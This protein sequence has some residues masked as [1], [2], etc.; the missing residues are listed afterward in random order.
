MTPSALTLS[1]LLAG[2]ASAL[3]F[4][5]F[6]GGPERGYERDDRRGEHRHERGHQSVQ[7]G[8]RPQWLVDDMD[9]SHLKRRL[10]RCD[11]NKP[12]SSRFSIGHRGAPLQFPEHTRESYI[13][14]A[15]MG[16]GILEC[17][18]AFTKDRELVCRHAQNDLHTT[19]NI[20]TI[21]ELNAKCT[22]PFVPA[23]PATG[24]QAQAECRTS[25]ITLAEFKQ[26]E[27]KMDAFNPDA[28]TPEQY[29]QGTADWRTDLYASRGTL[30]TH[31]DSIE[32]FKRLGVHMTPELKTPVVQMPY[33]GDYSQQD[34][35]RQML[36]DYLD[37]GVSPRKVRPQSFQLNDVLFWIN[38]MP[39]FADQ[40]VFL[41]ESPITPDTAS[42]A[43]MESLRTQGVK[44]L[45]PA[46]WKML[47]L[48]GR[49]DIVPSEYAENARAAGLD[50]IA[51]S[52][53]RSGPLADGGGWYYQSI[54]E[55]INNDGDMYEV[56][57]VLARDV[58]VI[59]IFSDWPATVT[60]YANCM[61]FR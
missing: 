47:T 9:D 17:D 51:W 59:G 45:A 31:Q 26:L 37:A 61:G 48:N 5:A 44:V 60:W 3:S 1:L 24:T 49:G 42:L 12:R 55:A 13:A 29:V 52:L 35:A 4:P 28:T 23:D 32:L 58:G 53:E 14:A 54:S 50:M 11:V 19:T 25:D 16:A 15:R 57:D 39:A 38:E 40:A 46:I 36:Q 30:M 56:V 41:D 43:Y 20:V 8:P 10:Q 21:P 34:Y 22:Q 18:V 27:G 33:E 6:A 2:A 7:L